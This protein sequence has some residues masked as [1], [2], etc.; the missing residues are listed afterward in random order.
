[1][2]SQL[3]RQCLAT[4]NAPLALV[5]QGLREYIRL[6][7][8]SPQKLIL[9]VA[10][11]GYK[12]DCISLYDQYCKI[13]PIPFHN[14][15][16]SD[17]VGH[18]ID[19]ADITKRSTIVHWDEITSTPFFNLPSSNSFQTTSQVWF[20]NAISLCLKNDLVR[21][22][23]LGGIGMWH[24]NALNYTNATL[25]PSEYLWNAFNFTYCKS[26]LSELLQLQYKIL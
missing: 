2:A 25:P 16:C 9:G 14:A 10:W 20:E 7:N 8:I 26:I 24:A 15:P 22:Y 4:S 1:M 18:Q 21:S 13:Q 17:A 6:E 5:Q 23:N 12:Y 19:F 3:Y 11:Y